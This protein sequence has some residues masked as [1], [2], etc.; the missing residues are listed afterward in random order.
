MLAVARTIPSSGAGIVWYEAR[1]E[2]IPFPDDGFDVVFC[3]LGL[4]F[5]VDKVAAIREMHRVLVPGGRV[6]VSTPP[7]K[8]VLR[9][10][11]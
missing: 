5:I 6:L 9:C 7:P 11:G 2:S 4:Q 1:A 8:C 3:Q 10:P